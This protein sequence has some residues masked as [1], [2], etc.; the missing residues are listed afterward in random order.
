MFP[1]SEGSDVRRDRLTANVA[2]F[3]DV[4]FDAALAF[5]EGSGRLV[6]AVNGGGLPKLPMSLKTALSPSHSLKSPFELELWRSLPVLRASLVS[7]LCPTWT[8][9]PNLTYLMMPRCR[10]PKR[11]IVS[12]S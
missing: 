3:G 12:D 5:G 6:Q 9:N 10:R 8:L 7:T 4:D 2:K 1:L 11:A